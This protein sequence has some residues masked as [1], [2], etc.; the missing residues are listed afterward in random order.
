MSLTILLSYVHSGMSVFLPLL[1]L[2]IYSES[3][4]VQ[5]S[6]KSYR[7]GGIRGCPRTGPDP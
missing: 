5:S 2:N 1:Q 6:A 4:P 7:G 3:S